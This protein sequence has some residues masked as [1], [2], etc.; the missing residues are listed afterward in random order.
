MQLVTFERMLEDRLNATGQVQATS[1]GAAGF[2]RL[3]GLLVQVD[4]GMIPMHMTAGSGTGD[5]KMTDDERAAHDARV[6]GLKPGNP[7]RQQFAPAAL[8]KVEEL[9]REV[10]LA[11]LPPAAVA[12]VGAVDGREEPGVKVRFETGWECYVKPFQG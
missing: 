4:G 8:R 7:P 11:D 6:A 2:P 9:I 3:Y 10:L 1:F 12:V 5:P